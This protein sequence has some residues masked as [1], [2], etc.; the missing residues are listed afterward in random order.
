MSNTICEKILTRHLDLD[1]SISEEYVNAN[2]DLIM[3]HEQLGGLVQQE[4]K[5]LG[6]DYVWDRCKNSG[7]LWTFLHK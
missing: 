7:H 6:I 3:V 4:Y 2:I 1:N 5:K